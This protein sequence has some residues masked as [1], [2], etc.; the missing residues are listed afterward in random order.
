MWNK[1]DEK[2][3]T[4][5]IYSFSKSLISCIDKLQNQNMIK[6]LIKYE[7]DDKIDKNSSSKKSGTILDIMKT[8]C[9]FDFP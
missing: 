1:E 2:T 4:F 9:H 8:S 5:I 7:D 6:H 3:K